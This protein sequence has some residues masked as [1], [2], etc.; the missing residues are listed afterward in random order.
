MANDYYQDELLY[1]RELGREFARANPE[2]A[3]Y[4]AEPGADPDV[5]RL[6]NPLG[7]V[8]P[9]GTVLAGFH[10]PVVVATVSF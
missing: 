5:E 2:A 9:P 10:W 6:L 1:L 7:P 8:L 4:L 3:K